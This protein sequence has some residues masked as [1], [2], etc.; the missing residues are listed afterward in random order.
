MEKLLPD[1]SGG[2]GDEINYFKQVNCRSLTREELRIIELDS[3][4]SKIRV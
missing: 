1:C 4:L 3:A 2:S